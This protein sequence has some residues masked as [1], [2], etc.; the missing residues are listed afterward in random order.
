VGVDGR[1]P[2]AQ[3]EIVWLN[4][5]FRVRSSA[6][7][8]VMD[9]F[10]KDEAISFIASGND[11]GQGLEAGYV[12][13][14]G[15]TQTPQFVVISSGSAERV[16]GNTTAARIVG[17]PVSLV[18]TGCGFAG[19]SEKGSS[20]ASPYVAAAAWLRYLY[21]V[22]GGVPVKPASIIR[23]LIAA[24]QPVPTFVGNIRSGGFF[25]AA[26]F[27][28][29]PSTGHLVTKKGAAEPLR[30]F[31]LTPTCIENG[32]PV[33]GITYQMAQL[34]SQREA[35]SSVFVAPDEK[36]NVRLWRRRVSNSGETSVTPICLLRD[37]ALTTRTSGAPR[38]FTLSTFT[39]D[40]AF[41]T[42][43]TS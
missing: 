22:S 7:S 13:Q 31:T 20:F 34:S 21:D 38:T 5:S 1:G 37:L 4:M 9:T 18:A 29:G 27:L 39:T 19:F 30:D 15:A 32:S 42:G 12:P 26:H 3:R 6:L 25:D 11:A 33:Q 40:V 35:V 24:S 10:R 28:A 8:L 23:D 14:D 41:I 36:K 16:D 17:P 43:P 2:E